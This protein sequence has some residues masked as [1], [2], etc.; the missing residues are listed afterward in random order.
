MLL[1]FSWLLPGLLCIGVVLVL[2]D[3]SQYPKSIENIEKRITK[4]KS[5]VLGRSSSEGQHD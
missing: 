3:V 5:K 2:R 1:M 4:L